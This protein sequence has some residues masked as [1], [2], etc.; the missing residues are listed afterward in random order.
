MVV[1]VGVDGVWIDV[2]V[3]GSGGGVWVDVSV[4]MDSGGA[5][6]V[7]DESDSEHPVTIKM[8]KSKKATHLQELWVFCLT[9]FSFYLIGR[10]AEASKGNETFT[11]R[12]CWLT[13]A[14][15]P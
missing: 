4:L 12:C 1:G 2:A 14:H 5:A 11:I 15:I 6:T 8:A 7:G 13:V 9:L 3:G 10:A